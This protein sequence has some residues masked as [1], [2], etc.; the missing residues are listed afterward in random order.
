MK[1]KRTHQTLIIVISIALLLAVIPIIGHTAIPKKI[2]YQGYLT[3]PQGTA[4]DGTVSIVFFIYSQS[5]GGTALWTEAQ[6]VTVTDGMFSTN[7]GDTTPITLPF[8]A[9]YYLG[10]TIGS[11]SEMTPRQPLTS[12]A[13]AFRAKEADSV[14]DNAVTTTIIA[15]DA[16]TTNKIANDAITGDKIAPTTVT[17]TNI[18]NGAVG[19]PQIGDGS[20]NTGDLADNA[21]TASKISPN[22]ISSIDGVSNDGGNVDLIAGPNVTITPSDSANT[23]TIAST[24][25]GSGSGDISDV[26]AGTGHS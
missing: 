13:Y 18:A 15:N 24:G 12:V 7:L 20:I 23:I 8:D 9:P 5:S 1:N 14:T 26:N 25:G 11:D 16:V 22:I 19:S 4:I 3:D 2:N 10:I 21:V 17:S 6:T